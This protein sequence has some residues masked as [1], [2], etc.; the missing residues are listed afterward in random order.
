[1]I[2]GLTG[3]IGSG[4]SYVASL[5]KAKGVP[6]YIS[7]IEA[8]KIMA[9]EKNVIKA[10]IK[11][12]GNEAYKNGKLNRVYIASQVFQNKEKL[13]RL[14]NIVHPAV[15]LHFSNWLKNQ[16]FPFVIKE[17][18]ILFET[19]GYKKCNHTILVTAPKEIRL[20]RVMKRDH[21][22]EIEVI[23][24]MG[25]QWEDEKKIPLADFLI[26]NIEKEKTKIKVNELFEFFSKGD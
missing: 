6:V 3:G 9:S 16:N 14:N 22:T 10:I 8:K 15:A 7:D 21:I 12:F 11:L 5:F 26:E 17:A 18:A 4:K 24:R 2:I 13:N 20:Q 23:K 25:N 1:M 19:G